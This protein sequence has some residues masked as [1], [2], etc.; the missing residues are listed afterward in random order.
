MSEVRTAE[1]LFW[2][3]L[4]SEE[5]IGQ[6]HKELQHE[7]ENREVPIKAWATDGHIYYLCLRIMRFSPRLPF[8]V[9]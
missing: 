9:T 3:N 1:A 5:R 4:H 8:P 2:G 6:A 7:A